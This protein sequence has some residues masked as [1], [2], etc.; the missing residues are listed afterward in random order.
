MH[1]N[2]RTFFSLKSSV[3]SLYY[4]MT[5]S[6]IKTAE[7]FTVSAS[8]TAAGRAKKLFFNI[9]PFGPLKHAF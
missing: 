5:K 2:L 8:T 3:R 6:F 7:I 4:Q 9:K 1:Q